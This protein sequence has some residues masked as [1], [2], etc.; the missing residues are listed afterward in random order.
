MMARFQSKYANLV[1]TMEAPKEKSPGKLI[2]FEGG[3]Y[4]T[5]D[6]AEIDF[7]R[8]HRWYGAQIVEITARDQRIIDQASTVSLACGY[9]DPKTG[10]ACEYEAS[11][12]TEEEASRKLNAHRTKHG[13]WPAG[14]KS[15]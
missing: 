15:G 10:R 7:I 8:K 11:G 13:H 3:V 1:L 9:V 5:S 6:P 12:E 4:E 2:R 14:A